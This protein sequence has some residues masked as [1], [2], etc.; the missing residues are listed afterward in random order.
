MPISTVEILTKIRLT[1]LCLTGF[2]LGFELYSR[3]VPLTNFIA[4]LRM[5]SQSSE[6]TL[7]SL[8]SVFNV[9]KRNPSLGAPVYIRFKQRTKNRSK[10]LKKTAFEAKRRLYTTG[11]V[12]ERLFNIELYILSDIQLQVKQTVNQVH[13]L[14]Q[15]KANKIDLQYK[16]YLIDCYKCLKL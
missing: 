13:L 10:S 2:S 12:I 15:E 5:H 14:V 11:K 7:D 16:I 8:K 6:S 3:W 9:C 1:M 4:L